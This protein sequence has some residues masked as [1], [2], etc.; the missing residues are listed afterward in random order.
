MRKGRQSRGVQALS[1]DAI[2][3]SAAS[4]HAPPPFYGSMPQSNILFAM[5]GAIL[6]MKTA[7]IC[8]S[9]FNNPMACCSSMLGGA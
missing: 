8:G 1:R 5:G 7:C 4:P 2:S 6:L 9:L 3:G